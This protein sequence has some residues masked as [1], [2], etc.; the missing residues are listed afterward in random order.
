MRLAVQRNGYAVF[1]RK[2]LSIPRRHVC[3][4]G[5]QKHPGSGIISDYPKIHLLLGGHNK[6]W[7]IFKTKN[8]SSTMIESKVVN[9]RHAP[10]IGMLPLSWARD[11]HCDAINGR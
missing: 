2:N 6:V 3:T 1:M 11:G 4:G 7:G 10:A 9:I 5:L 8:M